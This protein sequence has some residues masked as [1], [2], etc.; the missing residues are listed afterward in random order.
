[1]PSTRTAITPA[2]CTHT[3]DPFLC[4]NMPHCKTP[5]SFSFEVCIT[6]S[7]E[8]VGF[9]DLEEE[10][11]FSLILLKMFC[12]MQKK[13]KKTW[14]LSSQKTFT[15]AFYS[16]YKQLEHPPSPEVTWTSALLTNVDLI[17]LTSQS[18]L[19]AS[20]VLLIE[21][22]VN[23][24]LFMYR[25][26][27]FTSVHLG[28]FTTL[29]LIARYVNCDCCTLELFSLCRRP[30]RPN[31]AAYSHYDKIWPESSEEAKVSHPKW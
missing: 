19:L 25:V 15:R 7:M 27:T 17:L 13:K 14:S 10:R 23:Y 22:S 20:L 11:R 16:M 30:S 8:K 4:K 31:V 3:Y 21:N 12:H 9:A 5:T 1:M 6:V 26:R 18:L 29:Y 24:A 28:V 2:A